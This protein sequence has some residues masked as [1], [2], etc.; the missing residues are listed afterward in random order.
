MSTITSANAKIWLAVASI[1]PTAVQIQQFAVDDVFDAQP[2]PAAETMMGVDGK[3]A[4]GYVNAPVEMGFAIMA[5]SPSIDFFDGWYLQ[6]KVTQ[7]KFAASGTILLSGLGKQWALVNGF[8]RNYPAIPDA[9]KV[10]QPRKFA[11]VFE[12]ILPSPAV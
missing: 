12:S 4:A 9:K 8:L 11:I 6:E 5:N 7:D 1:F 3:L 10:L 2:L